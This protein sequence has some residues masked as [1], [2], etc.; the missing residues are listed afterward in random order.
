MLPVIVRQAERGV[1]TLPP[2]VRWGAAITELREDLEGDPDRGPACLGEYLEG[3]PEGDAPEAIQDLVAAHLDVSWRKGCG[4]PL[5]DY[6]EVFAARFSVLRSPADIPAELVEDEFLVRH[7][8]PGGDAPRLAEYARRFPGRP[9]VMTLLERRCLSG[10]RYVKLRKL[11][12][13]AMG[14]VWEARD[15][16]SPR[17]VAIKQPRADLVDAPQAIER[18]VAEARLTLG[19]DH[20]GVVAADELVQDEGAAPYLV[21]K[22]FCGEPLSARI[23][24]YHHPTTIRTRAARRC[25]FDELL[26]GLVTVCDAV[27]HAHSRGVLHQDLKPGNVLIGSAGAAAVLDWGMAIACD[28]RTI[29]GTPEYMAPEQADGKADASSDVFGLGAI[30]YEVLTGRPPHQ[31][32]GG[33]RPGDWRRVVREAAVERPRRRSSRVP[34]ALER[35]CLTALAQDHSARFPDAGTMA[36]ALRSFVG[37]VASVGPDAPRLWAGLRWLRRVFTLPGSP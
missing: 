4:R 2:H 19:L 35:I 9:E 6:V 13:G 3:I 36:E 15:P 28:D 32:G 1:R 33:E 14:E 8:L 16:A 18:F 30:L 20:P 27:A 22:L 11:G 29:V 12:Q 37:E 7:A 23:Q 5:E 17:L 31:W 25:L 34:R 26:Q 21:M 24:D 10:G